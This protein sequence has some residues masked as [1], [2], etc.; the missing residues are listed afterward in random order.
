[1]TDTKVS[2]SFWNPFHDKI[3][4]LRQHL[5]RRLDGL[6]RKIKLMAMSMTDLD[7]A[8]TAWETANDAAIAEVQAAVNDI[9]AA[10]PPGVDTTAQVARLQAGMQ[11]QQAAADAVKALDT[12]PTPPPTGR[13]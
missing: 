8:L 13:R 9:I 5:D 12:T 4:A 1:M 3:T 6:E 11:K 7:A 10:I 2:G